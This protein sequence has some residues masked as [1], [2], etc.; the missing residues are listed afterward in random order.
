MNGAPCRSRR[1]VRDAMRV[2]PWQTS[3]ALAGG[4]R[5]RT[6]AALVI[7]SYLC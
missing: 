5:L 3:V 6:Q 1:A 2:M 7:A 4:E